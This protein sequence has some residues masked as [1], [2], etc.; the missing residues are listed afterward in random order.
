MLKGHTYTELDRSFN[1]MFTR[2]KQFAIYTI[3]ALIDHIWRSLQTYD[4]HYV[5]EL[6]ALWDWHKYFDT[7]VNQRFKGFATSKFGS[8]M[9]EF[10]ARKDSSGT[11]RMWMRKS[12]QASSWLPEGKGYE[13]FDE[14][15]SGSFLSPLL[16]S[17]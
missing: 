5:Q 9:H 6:H 2:L 10:Y 17:A 15:P 8:G 3:D 14:V 16:S 4:C 12:S 13:V 11:V 7:T 1:T